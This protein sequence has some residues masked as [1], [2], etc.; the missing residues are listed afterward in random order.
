MLVA[1]GG[2]DTTTRSRRG[3]ARQAEE[4]VAAAVERFGRID[5]L[6]NNAGYGLFGAVEEV[7]DA[8]ARAIF[9]TNVFGLLTVTRAVLPPDNPKAR[10]V[11]PGLRRT[12]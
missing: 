2:R 8:E 9:D 1:E 12:G 4:A 3:D 11:G 7:S 5:V 10:P 6:V